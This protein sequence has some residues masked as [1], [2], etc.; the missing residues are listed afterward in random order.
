MK[1]QVYGKNILPHNLKLYL[2]RSLVNHP[3]NN[4]GHNIKIT[5][6]FS[7]FSESSDQQKGW[8]KNYLFKIL[9]KSTRWFWKLKGWG[10]QH[11]WSK[12]LSMLEYQE[13]NLLSFGQSFVKPNFRKMVFTSAKCNRCI[14]SVCN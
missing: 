6:K 13:R 9:L 5:L 7:Y 8:A 1:I 14:A 3:L 2:T 10:F 12:T 4:N 11:K